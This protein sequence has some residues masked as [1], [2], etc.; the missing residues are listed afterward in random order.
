[1]VIWIRFVDVVLET[2]EI[3]VLGPLDVVGR[4]GL[5]LVQTSYLEKEML[6]TPKCRLSLVTELV[7]VQCWEQYGDVSLEKCKGIMLPAALVQLTIAPLEGT[8]SRDST[9]TDSSSLASNFSI[10]PRRP[11]PLN[12]YKFE[13]WPPWTFILKL[14]IALRRLS[15]TNMLRLRYKDAE[16]REIVHSQAQSFTI[17]LSK[18]AKRKCL[19]AINESRAQKRKLVKYM[20]CLFLGQLLTKPGV[21]P[22]QRSC[23]EDFKKK[24]IEGLSQPHKRL[25]SLA[26]HVPHGYR[27][28]SLLEVSYQNNVPLF[29]ATWFIKVTYLNQYNLLAH[30]TK[31][32]CPAQSF[33]QKMFVDYLQSLLDEYLSRNNPH[34]APHSKD[35]SQQM[36]YTGSV[37]HRS[38]PSSAI[39]DSEEPSLHLKLWYVGPALALAPCRRAASSFIAAANLIW[40]FRNCYLSQSFVRTLVGVAVRFIHEPS[41]GGS[42]L[43]DNSRRAYTTSAL[44]EMASVSNIS[45]A[46]YVCRYG[47]FSF[48]TKCSVLCSKR[49]DISVKGF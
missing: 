43:V 41:P 18:N 6:A 44:I 39:L 46:G 32:S 38:D 21:Y 3:L 31:V 8:S 25:R 27:K 45:C 4:R 48:T 14:Q 34:S 33:G 19:R 23:G 13:T 7:V 47:L 49:W 9:R 20:A 10:N 28:K 12:P 42:D 29:R 26:D 37:Q 24:W 1:M 2:L 35:R 15:L 36:L 5:G 16:T 17:L 22:E 11:P 40:C 30:L